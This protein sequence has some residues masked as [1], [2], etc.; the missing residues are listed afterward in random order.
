MGPDCQGDLMTA[1]LGSAPYPDDLFFAENYRYTTW[2]NKAWGKGYSEGLDII[3]IVT[4]LADVPDS[5][6]IGQY[7]PSGRNPA[8]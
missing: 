1:Y 2:N 8:G 7:W 6:V 3:N 5:G 4:Y